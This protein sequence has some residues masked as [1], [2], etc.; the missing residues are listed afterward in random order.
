MADP[1]IR[2]QVE[3]GRQVAYHLLKGLKVIAMYRHNE[4]KYGEY[5]TK[6]WNA[7]AEYT[8]EYGSL[9]LRV[10]IT[11]FS[12]HKQDLFTEDNPVPYKF[13]KDGIR[14]IIF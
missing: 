11:N 1:A 12:L 14:Q 7:L 8:R 9:N 6:A 2:K 10:E 3:A 4:S 13:F 5:L